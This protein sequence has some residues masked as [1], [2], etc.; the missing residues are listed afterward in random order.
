MAGRR[1]LQSRRRP[2]LRKAD[3]SRR[4]VPRGAGT[5]RTG[6]RA[7]RITAWR[8]RSEDHQLHRSTPLHAQDNQVRLLLIGDTRIARAGS[9]SLPGRHRAVHP[10]LSRHERAQAPEVFGFGEGVLMID[11]APA[12]QR[13]VVERRGKSIA[14]SSVRRTSAS[15]ASASA[16]ASAALEALEKSVAWTM[17]LKTAAAALPAASAACGGT[18]RT[19]HEAFR[20]ISRP[21]RAALAQ[22]RSPARA[23]DNEIGLAIERLTEDSSRHRPLHDHLGRRGVV[24]RSINR[25]SSAGCSATSCRINGGAP[26]E[27]NG[28]VTS[29]TGTRACA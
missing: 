24:G 15:F 11:L 6:Q 27:P 12:W 13:D 2:L 3:G 1:R 22:T 16:Q 7:S 29:K 25:L 18:T 8:V 20:M 5:T 26:S 14:C 4:Y 10:R 28:A 19:G 23:H 9:P 17:R 21:I